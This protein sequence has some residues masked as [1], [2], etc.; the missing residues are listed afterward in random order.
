[1]LTADFLHSLFLRCAHIHIFVFLFLYYIFIPLMSLVFY[2]C[3]TWRWRA[4]SQQRSCSINLKIGL[5]RREK[6]LKLVHAPCWVYQTKSQSHPVSVCFPFFIYVICLSLV[7]G[8]SDCCQYSCSFLV[9]MFSFI[10]FLKYKMVT[11]LCL[12]YAAGILEVYR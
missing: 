9:A 10:N 3:Y 6:L 11:R 5:K 2:T 1:M 12:K 4:A 7:S 8:S